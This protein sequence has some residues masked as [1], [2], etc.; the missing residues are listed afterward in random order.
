MESFSYQANIA[1]IEKVSH[2]KWRG[3]KTW[4]FYSF[5]DIEI[6]VNVGPILRLIICFLEVPYSLYFFW[7]LTRFM[8]KLWP[9]K[10]PKSAEGHISC[11][12]LELGVNM[13]KYIIM[14]INNLEG[15]DKHYKLEVVF[16]TAVFD[17][18]ARTSFSILTKAVH[19]CFK[20]C[21][22][23][24][25]RLHSITHFIIS[26]WLT[27]NALRWDDQQQQQ[28]TSRHGDLW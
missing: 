8:Y 25:I 24:S 13:W 21:F 2:K 5:F 17:Y 28:P 9:Q 10:C 6:D 26:C 22:N 19:D 11:R 20:Q 27:V 7:M 1:R 16:W 14:H 18:S 12:T 4:H 3:R 23:V 15:I